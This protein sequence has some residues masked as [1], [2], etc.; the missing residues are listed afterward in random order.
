MSALAS[1]LR[2][3]PRTRQ[4]LGLA[5]PAI[6]SYILNNTYR[7]NDQFWIQ[8][9]GQNAQAAVGSTFFLQILHFA[10]VFLG[11]GGT[12]ALVSRA[13]GARDGETRDSIGRHALLFGLVVVLVLTGSVL[14]LLGPIRAFSDSPERRLGRRAAISSR[15]TSSWARCRSC[16]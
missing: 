7:I 11:V 10:L 5:W 1:R 16:P 3:S 14:A 9:L 6:V 15:S 2:P 4:V 13:V 12:L 8:G